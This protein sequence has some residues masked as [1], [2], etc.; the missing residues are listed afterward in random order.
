MKSRIIP[1]LSGV[2]E[3]GPDGDVAVAEL[4]LAHSPQSAARLVQRRLQTDL[5]RLA[6]GVVPEVRDDL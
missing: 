6:H 1:C 5:G 4:A 2:A 3:L